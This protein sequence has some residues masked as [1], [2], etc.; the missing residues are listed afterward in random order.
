MTALAAAPRLRPPWLRGAALAAISAAHAA[1]LGGIMHVSMISLSPPASVDTAVMAHGEIAFEAMA[2]PTPDRA[3]A[4]EPQPDAPVPE[5]QDAAHPQEP[6]PEEAEEIVARPSESEPDIVKQDDKP[7]DRQEPP[8]QAQAEAAAQ[9]PAAITRASAS[10]I[11][12]HD[13]ERESPDTASSL[14][15]RYAALVSAEI[16]RHKH[17]PAAA[18]RRGERGAVGVSFV[19]GASGTIIRQSITQSSGSRALD[20]SAAQMLTAARLPP[21]PGGAFHGEIVITFRVRP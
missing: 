15:A 17:Y 4:Q 12:M 5:P 9:P 14:A 18:R 2:T 1:A 8:E 11:G 10:S 3:V 7:P 16:N 19:V 13:S 20:A 6:A 21:P